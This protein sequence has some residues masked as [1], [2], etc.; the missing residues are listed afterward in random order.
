MKVNVRDL[1][2]IAA[3]S[4]ATVDGVGGFFSKDESHFK[5]VLDIGAL[6]YPDLT[7][8][9]FKVRSTT[10]RNMFNLLRTAR[11]IESSLTPGLIRAGFCSTKRI[12]MELVEVSDRSH[13]VDSY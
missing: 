10:G 2:M 9:Y 12:A 3:Q 13:A 4:G 6:R 5:N 8:P 11:F 1:A 7:N